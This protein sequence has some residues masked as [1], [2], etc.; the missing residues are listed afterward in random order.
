MIEMIRDG[1][2]RVKGVS[3]ELEAVT[4]QETKK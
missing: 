2:F 1:W 3:C 4:Y